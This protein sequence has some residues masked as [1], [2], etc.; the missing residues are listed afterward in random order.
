MG[1]TRS[2]RM[3]LC[4]GFKSSQ[5]IRI[6]LY[7]SLIRLNHLLDGGFEFLHHGGDLRLGDN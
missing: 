6:S 5:I 2:G 4:R 7:I 3:G 1:K